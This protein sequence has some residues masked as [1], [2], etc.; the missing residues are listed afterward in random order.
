MTLETELSLFLLSLTLACDATA[1]LAAA[2]RQPFPEH[3]GSRYP[4]LVVELWSLTSERQY[5]TS[6]SLFS[7]VCSRELSADSV[8][9]RLLPQA[10]QRSA[11]RW[12]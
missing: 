9:S 2:A 7:M 6:S 4:H 1:P 5:I 11:Q 3:R 8:S 12:R 10:H